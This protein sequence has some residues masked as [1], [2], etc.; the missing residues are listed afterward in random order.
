MVDNSTSATGSGGG[1]FFIDALLS[2]LSLNSR[3]TCIVI[4]TVLVISLIVAI[5]VRSAIFVTVC[6]RASLNLHNRMFDAIIRATMHFFNT[7]SSGNHNRV[8]FIRLVNRF[9]TCVDF[10]HDNI[11]LICLLLK[12]FLKPLGRILNRFSNDMGAID[13]ILPSILL[14]V[15]QVIRLH[16]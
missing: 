8:E 11:I 4:Y 6:T 13:E 1:G 7:N 10:N 2:S 16:Q 12:I 15:L 5:F 14:D 3:L 9:N